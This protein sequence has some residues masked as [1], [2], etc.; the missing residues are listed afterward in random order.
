MPK[1]ATVRT[2]KP[3]ALRKPSVLLETASNMAMGVAMGLAFALVLTHIT[4][5]G[6]ATLIDQSPAPDTAMLAI[7][8]ACVTMF[9]IGATL[10]GLLFRMTKDS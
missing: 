7:V 8:C 1:G 10:T 9:G 3:S 5:L 4:A 2:K 6:I